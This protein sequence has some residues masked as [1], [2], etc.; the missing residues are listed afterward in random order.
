MSGFV[1]VGYT[2]DGLGNSTGGMLGVGP[3]VVSNGKE[4]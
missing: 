2:P 3:V 4:D 1:S